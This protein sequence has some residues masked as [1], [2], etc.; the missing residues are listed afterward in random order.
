MEQTERFIEDSA[1]ALYRAEQQRVPIAPLSETYPF[2]TP[3]QAYAIQGALLDIKRKESPQDLRLIGHKIGLTSLPMQKLLGI[4]S[5]DYG[6]LFDTMVVLPGSKVSR[7]DFIEPRIEPEIGFW[8]AQDIRGPGVTAAQVLAATRGVSA[9]LELVDSRVA[10]WRIKLVDTIADNA[11]SARVIVSERVV[12]PH[13]L[14]LAQEAVSLLC[15]N[16]LVGSGTGS[17]VL[18]H[19]A[20]AVAWLANK[21]AEFG[22]GLQA[23]QLVLPGAMC[24]AAT[25][26][27]GE[28]YRATFTH[29]GD[30][31]VHFT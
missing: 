18:G 19:P 1:Q 12:S 20:E 3:A 22:I 27:A 28:T 11:S 6:V 24:A 15:N 14:D 29:L 8:L 10:D 5:P 13:E 4:D 2:L 17:A 31:E 23:G 16:E 9:A 7:A 21:L 25:V 26:S 30:I